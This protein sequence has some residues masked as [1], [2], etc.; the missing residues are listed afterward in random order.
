M[1]KIIQR[2][3]TFKIPLETITHSLGI[4]FE[5][6]PYDDV[7]GD[8]SQSDLESSYFGKYD[9]LKKILKR[10]FY[11]AFEDIERMAW[12]Q[13]LEA[14]AIESAIDSLLSINLTAE[15]VGLNSEGE[16]TEVNCHA[17]VD[18]VNINVAEGYAEVV[19]VNPEHLVNTCIDGVGEFYPHEILVDIA[20]DKAV[21]DRIHWILRY[22]DI[23]GESVIHHECYDP[24][25]VTSDYVEEVVSERLAWL[26]EKEVASEIIDS[27]MSPV[28]ALKLL[29]EFP[30]MFSNKFLES[31]KIEINDLLEDMIDNIKNKKVS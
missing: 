4:K 12:V 1:N 29:E 18:S 3:A 7:Y 10:P 15:Y 26:E 14:N 9:K 8:W 2:T 19:I 17:Y 27:N 20:Q 30:D 25:G 16:H 13:S 22:F 11:I 28:D 23:Y 6:D 21:Q 31:V 24:Y 5:Y